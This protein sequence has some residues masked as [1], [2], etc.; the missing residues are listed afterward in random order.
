MYKAFKFVSNIYLL[1]KKKK[2]D[3]VVFV[4]PEF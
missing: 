3:S 4:S 2:V 1:K